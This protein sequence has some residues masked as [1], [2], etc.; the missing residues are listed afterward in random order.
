MK[1]YRKAAE[2]GLASAQF[3]LGLKLETEYKKEKEAIEWYSKAAKQDHGWATQRI[4]YMY[5]FGYGL[6]QD[7]RKALEWYQKAARI[8]VGDKKEENHRLIARVKDK[9][10]K[11]MA[12][13]TEKREAELENSKKEFH[14]MISGW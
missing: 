12:K 6:G 4:G 2:Q 5:E 13:A 9:E 7:Y 3:E 14:S 8:L 11:L 10:A 1:W